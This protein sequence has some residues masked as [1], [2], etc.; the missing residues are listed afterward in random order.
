[1]AYDE[2]L[3]ERVRGLLRDQAVEEKKM[4]G[5]LAF[6]LDGK[7]AGGIVNDDLMVRVGPD[8]YDSML[9][10][11]GARPMDF[12]GR[13]SRGMVFVGPLGYETPDALSKWVERAKEFAGSI[14]T[15]RR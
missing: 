9:V 15:K 11:R 14:P 1:M 2:A 5:G 8:A 3:A 7:M 12:T 6:M 13:P 4:F 10:E